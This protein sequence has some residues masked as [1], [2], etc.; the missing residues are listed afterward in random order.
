MHVGDTIVALASG[1]SPA[2][3][4]L[5]RLSGPQTAAALAGLGIVSPPPAGACFARVQ[6]GPGRELP[7]QLITFAAPRS[8]TGEAAAELLLPGNQAL[9]QSLL[10]ALVNIPDVR[11]AQPGEFTARAHFNRRLSLDDARLIADLIA[12]QSDAELAAVRASASTLSG[13]TFAAWASEL[14]NLLALVEAGI[15][16]SDQE[17]VV[18]ISTSDL[19]LRLANVARQVA[20]YAGT[21]QGTEA[22]D[23]RADVLLFGAPNAGKSTLFNALL[24]RRRAVMHDHPG[25]TVDLLREPLPPPLEGLALVDSPGLDRTPDGERLRATALRTAAVVLWCDD[26]GRFDPADRPRCSAPVINVA[27]KADRPRPPSTAD[28][29][30]CAL[31]GT[32]LGRLRF[33]IREA[34]RTTSPSPQGLLPRHQIALADFAVALSHARRSLADRAG[35]GPELAAADLRACLTAISPLTGRVETADVL[36]RIFGSFCIGK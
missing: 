8:F 27:T 21:S 20:D 36:G 34:A 29:T 3:R 22:R 17:D 18:A 10:A 19:D 28:V 26:Q 6:L 15:D 24:G 9:V 32:N 30:L 35:Q 11:L 12:A 16:F 31:D 33:L 5:I 1:S 25:T 13:Q 2:P 4:A 23:G 14:T 7:L